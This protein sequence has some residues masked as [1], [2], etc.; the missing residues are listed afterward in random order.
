MNKNKRQ[1]LRFELPVD[2]KLTTRDGNEIVLKSHDISD[3]GIF[4]MGTKDELPNVGE[5]VVIQLAS[6]VAGDEPREINGLVVRYNSDGIGIH[7]LLDD[8]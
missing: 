7:F 2:V 4:L 6:L 3:S 8:E 5:E 1:H